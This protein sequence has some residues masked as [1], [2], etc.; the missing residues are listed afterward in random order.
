[1]K[2][3]TQWQQGLTFKGTNEAGQSIEMDG[4]GKAPSPMH[5]M[6]MAVGGCS[7]IDVV[8][9]LA[10][11]RQQI[12]DCVCH[13]DAERAE[14]PPRVFKK[15]HAH[16]VVTGKSLKE[17]QVERACQLSMEKYC[18]ASLML[19]ASVEISHSFEIVEE[20]E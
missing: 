12:S 9:I 4:E 8:M 19:Q 18:S 2:V 10:K 14:N 17:K 6:L 11:A 15:I 5:M 13:L 7:S 20:A 3:V 16:Y 1:M